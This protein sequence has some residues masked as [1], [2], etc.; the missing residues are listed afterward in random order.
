MKNRGDL[1]LRSLVALVLQVFLPPAIPRGSV[2]VDSVQRVPVVVEPLEPRVD[3]ADVEEARA[4]LAGDDGDEES[5]VR[6]EGDLVSMNDRFCVDAVGSRRE[7]GG[8][9]RVQ[10]LSARVDEF[11]LGFAT[12]KA[13]FL[14]NAVGLVLEGLGE[15]G[16]R[17]GGERSVCGERKNDLFVGQGVA[18]G[19]IYRNLVCELR[20]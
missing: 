7:R 20:W 2:V 1:T 13:V 11:S 16:G 19:F 6:V 12:A 5:A 18:L 4:D 15:E 10:A 17:F 8:E 9:G 14:P 3:F